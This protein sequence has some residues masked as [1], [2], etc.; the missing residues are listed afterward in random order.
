MQNFERYQIFIARHLIVTGFKNEK[1]L[2][3]SSLKVI[4]DILREALSEWTRSDWSADIVCDSRQVFVHE[5]A[6]VM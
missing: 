4:K 5:S 1:I 3:S 6:F 2:K